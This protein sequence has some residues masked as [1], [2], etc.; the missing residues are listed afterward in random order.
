M[1]RITNFPVTTE[2]AKKFYDEN[3]DMYQQAM[4]KVIFI[5]KTF[6]INR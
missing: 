4:V 6:E 2:I 1:R 3:T 5:S